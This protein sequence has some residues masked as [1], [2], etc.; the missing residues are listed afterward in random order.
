MLCTCRLRRQAGLTGVSLTTSILPASMAKG[1]Y[2]PINSE[3]LELGLE[4][5]GNIAST[6]RGS[7]GAFAGANM[8][9]PSAFAAASNREPLTFRQVGSGTIIAPTQ[10]PR[11]NP[12]MTPVERP[13]KGRPRG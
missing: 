13:S 5:V 8:R 7:T 12:R 9:R 6:D 1:L 11:Y 2:I 3:V 4:H 10:R